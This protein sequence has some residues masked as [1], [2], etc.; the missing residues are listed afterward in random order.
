LG[1]AEGYWHQA[2]QR[3]LELRVEGAAP[4]KVDTWAAHRN[5]P[6]VLKFDARDVNS[7]GKLT[8]ESVAA[9]EAKDQNSILNVV[10]IFSPEAKVDS[11]QLLKGTLDKQALA[12]YDCGE[13]EF[14]ER[15]LASDEFTLAPG[16]SRTWY[17]L[18][19]AGPSAPPRY[20]QAFAALRKATLA[21]W[22]K[23]YGSLARYEVPSKAVEDLY[24]AS[25]ANIVITADRVGDFFV[26]KPGEGIYDM[27]WYRD[28]AYLVQ[29]LDY[30]GLPKLAAEAVKL[31]YSQGVPPDYEYA[32]QKPAGT[33]DWPNQEW[34]G[35]GQAPW[36]IVRHYELTGDLSELEKAWPALQRGAEWTIE[37]LARQKQ[38]LSPD[39]P[40]Y[41]LL[42]V[43]EGEAI[44]HTYV[45]YHNFWALFGLLE[46]AKAAEYL[47]KT[48]AAKHY[49]DAWNSYRDDLLLS[50]RR[51]FVHLPGGEG[52]VPG[53]PGNPKTL[54]WGDV[55]LLWP[56]GIYGPA[57]SL[58]QHTFDYLEKQNAE[59]MYRFISGPFIW[60]YIS[61]D[62][63]ESYLL[64][65]ERAKAWG[66]FRA[67]LNHAAL[68][69][70]WI[71]G[72]LLDSHFGTGDMPHCWAAAD[73]VMLLRNMLLAERP[74]GV[75]E[76][77]PGPLPEWLEGPGIRVEGAST[78]FGSLD[79]TAHKR[80]NRF[81]LVLKP[82]LRRPFVLK[83]DL[84]ALLGKTPDTVL[85]DGKPCELADGVLWHQVKG[86]CALSV[87]VTSD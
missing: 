20:D 26:V 62:W 22:R 11:K 70:T 17:A 80:G 56:C 60:L 86:T 14:K 84:K 37:A 82:S 7:D 2:G 66:I 53:E 15:F 51:Y 42:P 13:D 12:V 73:F 29:A 75:L 57:D 48:E 32:R 23:F 5:Q 68:N 4:V 38:Q 24:Y 85:V 63:A 65:G 69:R 43:G 87:E 47:Q 44:A 16:A 31:F 54:I 30:A 21:F 79:F 8:I 28:G 35:Q 39:Q 64:S 72:I 45:Y 58:L 41:G 40:G 67:Y 52:Y 6:F 77:L 55:N 74:G 36:A 1:L 59:G 3:I 10:W 25:V 76:L 61:T 19:P 9:P 50:L 49:L 78:S 27:F 71:E 34:D 83:L 18:A 33:W 46:T 81:S